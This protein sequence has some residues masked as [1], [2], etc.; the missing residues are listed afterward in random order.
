[1]ER[2][3]CLVC[4]VGRV[5]RACK[6]RVTRGLQPTVSYG[7]D[8]HG[9]PSKD[10]EKW[11]STVGTLLFGG[12]RG[13]SLQVGYALAAQPWRDPLCVTAERTLLAWAEAVATS[14]MAEMADLTFAWRHGLEQQQVHG[15]EGLAGRGPAA[16]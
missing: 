4:G 3:E 13:R 9:W 5:G 8:A 2:G 6:R 7:C 15:W 12:A 10:L 11:R 16:G 14:S 1:M